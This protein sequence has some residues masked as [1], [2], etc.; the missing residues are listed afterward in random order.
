[1]TTISCLRH[2]LNASRML[3]TCHGIPRSICFLSGLRET[4][5]SHICRQKVYTII[6]SH[7]Q[8]YQHVKNVCM[9][10]LNNKSFFK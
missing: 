3:E 9:P 6:P 1:M 7:N 10:L 2:E 5:E 8:C 4:D